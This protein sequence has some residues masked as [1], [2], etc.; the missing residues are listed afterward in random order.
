VIEA[1]AQNVQPVVADSVT[2]YAGQRYSLV[3]NAN[4]TISN[5]WIRA[6]PNIGNTSTTGGVNSAILRYNGAA[7]TDPT[8][9]ASLSQTL[10]LDALQETSLHPYTD[11]AAPGTAG[12]GEADVN[13]DLAILFTGSNYTINGVEFQPPSVPVLLQILSGAQSATDLLPAGSVYVLPKNK[14]IELTI[15]S[16][17]ALGGPH[18]FHLH[19]VGLELI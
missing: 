10:G 12:L 5:Y 8:T 19:G 11:P 4:Q 6:I 1:D 3:L 16:S 15:P 17:V 13:I 2:I 14:V 9:N 7:D 18:P